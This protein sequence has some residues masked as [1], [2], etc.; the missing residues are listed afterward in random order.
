MQLNTKLIIAVLREQLPLQAPLF[1]Y[2]GN[3]KV[4]Y[5]TV[6]STI[7]VYYNAIL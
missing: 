2:G 6:C 1:P 3:G 5:S 4:K 7:L